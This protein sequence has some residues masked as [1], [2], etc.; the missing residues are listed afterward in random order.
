MT[1]HHKGLTTLNGFSYPFCWLCLI[2]CWNCWPTETTWQIIQM[3]C[4][5]KALHE[6][7][8]STCSIHLRPFLMSLCLAF[9]T[10]AIPLKSS[11]ISDKLTEGK[12]NMT[13]LLTLPNIF[14]QHPLQNIINLT[15]LQRNILLRVDDDD[16]KCTT[17]TKWIDKNDEKEDRKH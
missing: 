3:N 6:E 1:L 15:G 5:K 9:R 13:I 17:F 11:A 12:T 14:S 2:F 7:K 10:R 16:D 8:C 4:D